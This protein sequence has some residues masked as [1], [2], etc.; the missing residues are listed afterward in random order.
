MVLLRIFRLTNK[1]SRDSL[2]LDIFND[3]YRIQN[4]GHGAYVK[5]YLKDG[6]ILYGWPE[7][8]SDQFIDGPVLFLSKA[9]WLGEDGEPLIEIP[10]PGIM[11]MGSQI[12]NIEF[13]YYSG[14]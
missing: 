6:K 4:E 5:V 2:W 11:I 3:K 13:R 12:E 10:N 14:E 7:Y 8:F 9:C 1:T